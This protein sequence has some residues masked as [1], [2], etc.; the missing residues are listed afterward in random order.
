MGF[1]GHNIDF[2]GFFKK[3]FGG[4]LNVFG[5]LFFEFGGFFHLFGKGVHFFVGSL[6]S[7]FFSIQNFNQRFKG[8]NGASIIFSLEGGVHGLFDFFNELNFG[9]FLHLF[10]NV[11]NGR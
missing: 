8:S 3:V 10:G 11:L 1:S 7:L 9:G 5:G 2:V 6:E 4:G